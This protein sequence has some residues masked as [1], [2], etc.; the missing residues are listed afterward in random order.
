MHGQ[1]STW[2][3]A[4]PVTVAIAEGVM[5]NVSDSAYLSGRDTYDKA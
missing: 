3:G 5:E 1:L 2:G 4:R